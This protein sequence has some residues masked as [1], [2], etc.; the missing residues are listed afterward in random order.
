M[1]NSASSQ[2]TTNVYSKAVTSVLV[3][4]IMQCNTGMVAAQEIN[5]SGSYNVLDIKQEQIVNFSASCFQSAE[6]IVDLQNQIK[7]AI[8]ETAKSQSAGVFNAL[9]SSD[10]TLN[11][12]ITTDIQNNI[13]TENMQKVV[14]NIMNK[15][16]VNVSGSNNVAKID[17]KAVSDIVADSAQKLTTQL[18]SLNQ[19]STD[20]K[21]TSEATQQDPVKALVDSVFSGLSSIMSLWIWAF[22]AIVIIGAVF[23]YSIGFNPFKLLMGSEDD[24]KADSQ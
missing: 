20:V 21:G 18:K 19:L 9:S 17:Q 1:G 8:D 15:Q 3:K 16:L 23:C 7:A 4:N 13:T 2:I 10:S 22:I 12:N 11:R 14:N 5:I 6:N 24:N